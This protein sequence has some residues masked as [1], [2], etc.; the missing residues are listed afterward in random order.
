[1]RVDRIQ[2]LRRAEK[3]TQCLV[4]DE[5]VDVGGELPQARQGR[6]PRQTGR[7][8][9]R[10]PGSVGRPETRGGVEELA[11]QHRRWRVRGKVEP[12]VYEHVRVTPS[13]AWMRA[14]SRP[15]SSMPGA[16]TRAMTS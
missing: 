10:T 4:V 16:W 11:V 2:R 12:G 9:P 3:H 6:S 5:P 1:M 15:S 14:T 13:T 7:S 8:A